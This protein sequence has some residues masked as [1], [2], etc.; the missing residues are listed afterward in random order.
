M[1]INTKRFVD[2]NIQH[3]ETSSVNSIRDT[4]VLIT[5]DGSGIAET[6]S[7]VQEFKEAHTDYATNYTHATPY[8][9]A[10]FTNGGNKLRLIKGAT[11]TAEALGTLVSGLANEFIVVAFDGTQAHIQTV[12]TTRAQ[13]S[14][15]YGINRKLLLAACSDATL[16]SILDDTTEGIIYKYTNNYE[17]VMTIAAYLTNID[18]YGIN[19]VQDYCFTKETAKTT[20]DDD[21][22]YANLSEHN[23]NVDAMLAGSVRNLGGNAKNG[24]DLVNE[25]M[26]IVLHQTLTDRILTALTSKLKNE[27]GLATIKTVMSEELNR[28]ITNGYLRTSAIWTDPNYNV[29][30]NGK[31]YTVV[32][33]DTALPLGY[34]IKIL[35]FA[36]LSAEDKLLRA[37]PPIYLAVADSYGIRKVT[38][39][40]EVF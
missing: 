38:V 15:I 11:D 12:A 8:I 4:A 13:S 3:K 31:D 28:Y 9:E 40:G 39:N 36:D 17:D 24:L 18:I 32:E 7:S 23:I 2:I 27:E 30:Y 16:D 21:T 22:L 33:Q 26:L 20:I 10:F 6:F 29:Q 19:T 1:S 35:P 34:R 37:T 25:F 5:I 14:S